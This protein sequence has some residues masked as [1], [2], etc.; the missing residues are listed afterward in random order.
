MGSIYI[1]HAPATEWRCNLSYARQTIYSGPCAKPAFPTIQGDIL[2]FERSPDT[3]CLV[4]GFST[5]I[6]PSVSI[7]SNI[8]QVAI[9]KQN[10]ALNFPNIPATYLPWLSGA[11]R[12]EYLL[13]QKSTEDTWLNFLTLMLSETINWKQ[14]GF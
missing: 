2:R 8:T 4:L 7:V 5:T 14:E 13:S 10:P 6:Q 3:L 12:F 9:R 11:C 1:S